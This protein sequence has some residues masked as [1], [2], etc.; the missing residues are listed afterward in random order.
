MFIGNL[1]ENSKYDSVVVVVV[2]VVIIIVII[3]IIIIIIIIMGDFNVKI[4]KEEYQKKVAGKFITKSSFLVVGG[5]FCETLAVTYDYVYGNLI[6][7]E[8]LVAQM[9]L[10]L[11]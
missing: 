1:P 5:F 3:I 4:G 8:K 2:V 6:N 11:L 10:K 9:N 7:V